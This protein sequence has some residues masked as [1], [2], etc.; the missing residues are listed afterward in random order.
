MLTAQ[1]PVMRVERGIEEIE[2]IKFAEDD[3][4]EHIIDGKRTGGIAGLHLFKPRQSAVVVEDVEAVVSLPNE[5]VQI[6]RIRIHARGSGYSA[7]AG[8][9]KSGQNRG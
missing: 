2:A 6:E 5:G 7:A 4:I 3:R 1:K 9:R 8:W